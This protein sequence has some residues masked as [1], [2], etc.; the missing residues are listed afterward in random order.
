[1][2]WKLV[3]IT[4]SGLITKPEPNCFLCWVVWR[5]CSMSA[6]APAILGCGTS[7]STKAVTFTTFG[8]RLLTSFDSENCISWAK[9][10]RGT[11]TNNERIKSTTVAHKG[12][13]LRQPRPFLCKALAM[14]YSATPDAWQLVAAIWEEPGGLPRIRKRLYRCRK[15]LHSARWRCGRGGCHEGWSPL[16]LSKANSAGVCAEIDANAP[17]HHLEPGD[18]AFLRIVSG[19]SHSSASMSGSMLPGCSWPH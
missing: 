1:M 3:T 15:S 7:A 10:A 12:A 9:D 16:T 17:Y 19:C 13:T 2:T 6:A 8:S 5:S 18:L 4:P 11:M 14:L